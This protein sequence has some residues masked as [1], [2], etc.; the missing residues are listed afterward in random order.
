MAELRLGERLT[1]EL[2]VPTLVLAGDAD[3][4]LKANIRDFQRMPPKLASLHVLSRV[5]C[6]VAIHAPVETA[7]AIDD[8]LTNGVAVA[9]KL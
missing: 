4:L 8:F 1:S 6:E 7:Q 9:G 2:T 5:G 3:T